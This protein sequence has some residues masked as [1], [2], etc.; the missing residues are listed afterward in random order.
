MLLQMIG[1]VINILVWVFFNDLLSEML[2]GTK[3]SATL[4]LLLILLHFFY[5]TYYLYKTRVND[6]VLMAMWG[7]LRICFGLA[8]FLCI[9]VEKRKQHV[10]LIVIGYKRLLYNMCLEKESN[11]SD[12]YNI[13]KNDSLNIFSNYTAII[14]FPKRRKAT[15]HIVRSSL[16]S[17]NLNKI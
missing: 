2:C 6:S 1:L 15:L 14:N 16:L 4:E 11:G 3:K 17:T 9:Y 5:W 7:R 10:W 8:G 13:I 12:Y